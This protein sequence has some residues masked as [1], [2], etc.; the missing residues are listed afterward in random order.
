MYNFEEDMEVHNRLGL[1]ELE[2]IDSFSSRGSTTVRLKRGRIM[3]PS[4]HATLRMAQRRYC[5]EQLIGR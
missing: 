4:Q 1:E 2:R 3:E 5:A